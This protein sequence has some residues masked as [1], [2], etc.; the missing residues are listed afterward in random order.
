MSS[1][2]IIF[3]TVIAN[4]NVSLENLPLFCNVT[5]APPYCYIVSVIVLLCAT[6]SFPKA[7]FVLTTYLSMEP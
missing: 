6:L 3:L 7:V 5:A 4:K 1:L 2:L